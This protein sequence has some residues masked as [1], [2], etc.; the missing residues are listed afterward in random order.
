MAISNSSTEASN[1]L[2]AL[3][4]ALE[5]AA[6]SVSQARADA[7]ESAKLA[8]RRVQFGVS[9]GAYYSAYGIS[10]GLVFTGVFL[11][12]L[13][14]VGNP[15]RRGFEDGAAAAIEDAEQTVAAFE[16]IEHPALEEDAGG[17]AIDPEVKPD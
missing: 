4:D 15:I 17:D 13:L 8:A 3:G 9:S 10:Y 5:S 14:P 2:S 16:D 1:T 7:T 6:D 11:K 12:E